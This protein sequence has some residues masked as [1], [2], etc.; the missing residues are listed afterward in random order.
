[1]R[2]GSDLRTDAADAVPRARPHLPDRR[3][4][5]ALGSPPGGAAGRARIDHL[6][7]HHPRAA[8]A[9]PRGVRAC[10][11]PRLPPRLL[12]RAD[13]P[14]PDRLDDPHHPEDRRRAHRRLH[15]AR[16]GR[17]WRN[18][19]RGRRRLRPGGG[20]AG[21]AA[22]EHLPLGQHRLG[23][24]AGDALR[25]DGDRRLGGRRRGRDQALRLH[26]LRPRPRDGWALPPGRSLLPCLQGARARLL[27]RV[28][29]AGRKDQPEP[30]ALLRREDGAGAQR[31]RQAD[32]GIADP[33]ARG[34][35]QARGR[36]H[37]R[38]P[39][40]ED[41]AARARAGRGGFLPR[42]TRRRAARPRTRIPGPRRGARP[43]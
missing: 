28:H 38:V 24:R 35:L 11:R 12:S 30:A 10:R 26:A 2:G 34:L 37:A 9:D 41:D 20:G 21:E 14:R 27:H 7:G 13:R 17:L 25:P 43:L 42:P 8:P 4:H 1:M 19:R 29:R 33:A 18:L 32:E 31:R 23:E 15:R 39:G 40:A 36:R 3:R 16:P 6:P 22:R 5:L